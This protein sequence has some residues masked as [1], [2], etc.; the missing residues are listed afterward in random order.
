MNGKT[1]LAIALALTVAHDIRTQIKAGKAAK[2]FLEALQ[3]HEVE[4]A[5]YSAQIMYLCHMLDT[6]DVAADEFD[7]I[8]LHFHHDPE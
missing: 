1:K 2:L 4:K 5:I 6:H 7:L 3:A 8:A